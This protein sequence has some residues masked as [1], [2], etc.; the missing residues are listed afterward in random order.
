MKL[1]VAC[2]IIRGDSPS[3]PLSLPLSLFVFLLSSP[4]PHTELILHPFTPVYLIV[5]AS[6]Y[7]SYLLSTIMSES[8][9]R[10]DRESP[11]EYKRVA[12]DFVRSVQA[13]GDEYDRDTFVLRR[14]VGV[15][16]EHLAPI[17]ER[18]LQNPHINFFNQRNS[19][20]REVR[21]IFTHHQF[22]R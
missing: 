19:G 10:Y 17:S 18:D 11:E 21:S 13:P 12:E 5:K 1:V 16:N 4:L 3:L 9:P 14:R 6:T 22:L 15:A 8:H 20:W 2:L 7:K